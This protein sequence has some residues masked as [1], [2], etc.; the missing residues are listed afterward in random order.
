M[1]RE[2]VVF[3]LDE[4][5]YFIHR[6]MDQ[7]I[8][9]M[10]TNNCVVL[11]SNGNDRNSFAKKYAKTFLNEDTTSNVLWIDSESV[12]TMCSDF[13]TIANSVKMPVLGLSDYELVKRVFDHFKTE[14]VLF[15]FANARWD[16]VLLNL[17]ATMKTY[18]MKF[19]VTSR[20]VENWSSRF[21]VANIDDP[22]LFH[23]PPPQVGNFEADARG[24]I[25]HDIE[26]A[27]TKLYEEEK[28]IKTYLNRVNH[29]RYWLY[30]HFPEE[31]YNPGNYEP[32]ITLDLIRPSQMESIKDR[33][34]RDWAEK[35]DTLFVRAPTEG[36]ILNVRP[37]GY[38][39]EKQ[40]ILSKIFSPL[41]RERSDLSEHNYKM[42]W[43]KRMENIKNE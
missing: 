4:P 9:L 17:L 1:G 11:A 10:K 29:D 14:R 24:G 31:V 5:P 41:S 12:Q 35:K 34:E 36:P 20:D 16:N 22:F 27:L 6:D 33:V 3:H 43:A 13:E 7:I 18:N 37:M 26:G 2:Q 25:N 40:E 28:N 38:D 39:M 30:S 19:V 23:E 32:S 21:I 42:K 15:I 8:N